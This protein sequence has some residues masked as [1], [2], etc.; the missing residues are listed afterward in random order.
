MVYAVDCLGPSPKTQALNQLLGP[1]ATLIEPGDKDA[2]AEVVEDLDGGNLALV[3]QSPGGIAETAEALVQY[4]RSRFDHITVVVPV[5]AKSAATMLAL[6]ADELYLDDLSEL[7][8]I[9]PQFAMGSG[10]PSPAPAIIRQFEQARQDIAEH[11]EHLPAWA[12]ILQQYA[13]SLLAHAEEVWDLGRRMVD[14]WLRAYMFRDDPDADRKVERITSYFS[15]RDDDDR[16]G[17]HAR[18]I[19]I[20]K[21]LELELRVNDLRKNPGLHKRVRELHHAINMTLAETGTYKLFENSTGQTFA[22]GLNVQITAQMEP[23]PDQPGGDS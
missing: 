14:G 22:R 2:L 23:Q 3:L 20:D 13:P 5:Y 18:P 21:A 7:G 12:P 17:S 11:P 16:P 10:V 19:G 9:D 4:L 15:G 8:P 6:S 1:L